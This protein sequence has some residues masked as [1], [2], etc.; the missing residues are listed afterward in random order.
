MSLYPHSLLQPKASN[1]FTQP[2]QICPNMLSDNSIVIVER[3]LFLFS[4]FN[5]PSSS[6]YCS[7][8]LC[9]TYCKLLLLLLLLRQ[10]F[11]EGKK[12]PGAGLTCAVLMMQSSEVVWVNNSSIFFPSWIQKKSRQW[13]L[14]SQDINM[15]KEI[16]F[17]GSQLP[18]VGDNSCKYC[19]R[20][21]FANIMLDLYANAHIIM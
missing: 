16:D 13:A 18:F 20:G 7:S 21:V 8:S 1:Q 12:K 4:N 6:F 5:S 2:L 14:K 15:T 9:S 11:S 17:Y 19:K 3:Y 10:E